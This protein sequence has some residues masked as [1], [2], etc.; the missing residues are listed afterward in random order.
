MSSGYQ[1]L[2]GFV[3]GIAALFCAMSLFPALKGTAPAPQPAM[4]A[5]PTG[6]VAPGY[7]AQPAPVN[8]PVYTFIQED[9]ENE[10]SQE[11]RFLFTQRAVYLRKEP[12]GRPYE[13]VCINRAPLVILA[14]SRVRPL[15]TQGEW[16]MVRTPG[17]TL[18]WVE[19]SSLS[20]VMPYRIRQH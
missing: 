1:Y 5:V 16:V 15:Q 18:G 12:A 3:I 17:Q 6:P 13:P 8:S 10:K 2:V 19:Q 7:V 20:D 14:G 9:D 4:A 11:P